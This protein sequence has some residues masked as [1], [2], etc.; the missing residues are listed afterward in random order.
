MNSDKFSQGVCT[1]WICIFIGM[2]I[3]CIIMFFRTLDTHWLLDAVMQ[4]AA[5]MI[6]I[7]VKKGKI[8]IRI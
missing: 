4:V 5:T 8:R 7:G 2:G 3:V 1:I 6:T